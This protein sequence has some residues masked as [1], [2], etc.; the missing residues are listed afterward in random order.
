MIFLLFLHGGVGK[1]WE[2]KRDENTRERKT[3]ILKPERWNEKQKVILC[4]GDD[5]FGNDFR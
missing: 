2:L 5:I 4:I 3:N 1:Y